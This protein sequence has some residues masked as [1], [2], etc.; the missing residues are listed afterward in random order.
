MFA[1]VCWSRVGIT[2]HSVLFC[3]GWLRCPE[4]SREGF[5][6][7]ER[8]KTAIRRRDVLRAVTTMGV[9]AAASVAPL[10]PAAADTDTRASRGKRRSLYQPN[11]VEVQAFYRVNSYPAK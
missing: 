9:A 5:S 10:S 11:A 7:D 3:P 6:M 8:R 1:T 4:L 2:R